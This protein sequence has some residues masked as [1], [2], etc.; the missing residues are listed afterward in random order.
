MTDEALPL[1]PARAD[2]LDQLVE[3]LAGVVPSCLPETVWQLP[4]TW[5]SYLVAE[6]SDGHLV[7]AGSAQ[8]VDVGRVEIR[9]LVVHPDQRGHGLARRVVEAL[10]QRARGDGRPVVCVTKKPQFFARLGF[11][12][13]PSTWMSSQ[14]R[15]LQTRGR[16]VG[17]TH[18][19]MREAS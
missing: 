13:T 12:E 17:M 15:Q 7:A 3:L 5:S 1:R 11:R 19:P 6:D 14:R 2:D 9:G 16:R 10:V 4:W 18:H 8:P